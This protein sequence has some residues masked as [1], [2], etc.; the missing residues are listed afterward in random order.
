MAVRLLTG[1]SGLLLEADRH[2]VNGLSGRSLG[3]AG[4]GASGGKAATGHCLSGGPLGW[5]Q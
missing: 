5:P 3:E 2:G 1:G 4:S